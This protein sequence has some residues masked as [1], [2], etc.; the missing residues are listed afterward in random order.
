[1]A[2]FRQHVGKLSASVDKAARL[3]TIGF[4]QFVRNRGQQAACNSATFKA[5]DLPQFLDACARAVAVHV[6]LAGDPMRDD[7]DQGPAGLS[8]PVVHRAACER[9][10]QAVNVNDILSVACDAVKP[11]APANCHA[12]IGEGV[13]G[14]LDIQ[15]DGPLP[16]ARSYSA[17]GPDFLSMKDE[18][19]DRASGRMTAHFANARGSVSV[20][21]CAINKVGQTCGEAFPAKLRTAASDKSCFSPHPPPLPCG[22]PGGGMKQCGTDHGTPICIPKNKPCT[23]GHPK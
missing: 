19:V 13:C 4:A 14:F 9:A 7:C 8:R 6:P 23:D 2:M 17:H 15:C 22:S 16:Q 20:Q 18:E 11:D 10:I 1:M 5:R 3:Y 12:T 21:V